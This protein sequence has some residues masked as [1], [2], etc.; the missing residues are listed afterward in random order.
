L[1]NGASEIFC[2]DPAFAIGLLNDTL[3]DGDHEELLIVLR[4]ISATIGGAEKTQL[5]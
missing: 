5:P 2:K 3:A 1:L 4:Q